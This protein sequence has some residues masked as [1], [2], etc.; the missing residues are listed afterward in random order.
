MSY[1]YIRVRDYF[2]E[3]DRNEEEEL[4]AIPCTTEEFNLAFSETLLKS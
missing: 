4:P 1:I 3:R 2:L